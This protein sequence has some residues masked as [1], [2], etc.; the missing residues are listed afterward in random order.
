MQQVWRRIAEE[1]ARS[2][3]EEVVLLRLLD[4]EKAYSRVYRLA[5]WRVWKR[6]G[7][8]TGMI[9]VLMLKAI[10]NHTDMKV[11]AHGGCSPTY[12]PECGLPER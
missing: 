9:N 11:R 7:C 2:N 3:S 6:R 10:H 1:I 4:I 12:V 8:P 5:T